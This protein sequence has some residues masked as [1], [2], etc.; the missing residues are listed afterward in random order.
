M[1]TLAH[2]LHGRGPS[3]VVMLHDWLGDRHNWDPVVPYLDEQRFTYVLVDL[4]GYG[5]SRAIA[6]DY[7]VDEAVGDVVALTSLLGWERFAAV[8]HSMSGLIVQ[9][10]AAAAPARVSRLVAVTPCPP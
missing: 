8:G 9:A 5:E 2:A 1:T 10:L 3:R 4:R 6:G 7:T